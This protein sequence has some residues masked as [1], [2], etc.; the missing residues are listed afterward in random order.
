MD[1]GPFR[2]EQFPS[3]KYNEANARLA[4]ELDKWQTEKRV[5]EFPSILE[6]L[7]YSYVFFLIFNFSSS[8]LS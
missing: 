1:E 6:F 3:I 8:I 7:G 2:C 4:Q 5:V